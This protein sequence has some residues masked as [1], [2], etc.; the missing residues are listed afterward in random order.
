MSCRCGKQR[1]AV[2]YHWVITLAALDSALIGNYYIQI[3]F[4]LHTGYPASAILVLVVKTVAV[5]TDE[6][7]FVVSDVILA[8]GFLHEVHSVV[9]AVVG[10]LQTFRGA[11]GFTNF[12]V[13]V[14]RQNAVD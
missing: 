9:V 14:L 8:A 1:Q 12:S 2:P 13:A 10:C 4:A 3:V 6:I 5:F 7:R 11:H